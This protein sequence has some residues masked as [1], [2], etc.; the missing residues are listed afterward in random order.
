MGKEAKIGLAVILGLL[1]ILG[2]VITVR[3][4]SFARD[5]GPDLAD[6]TPGAAGAESP[7]SKEAAVVPAATSSQ[8]PSG[9]ASSS[10]A[11]QDRKPAPAAAPKPTVLSPED[12]EPTTRGAAQWRQFATTDDSTN[13][14]A[15]PYG[16][17][18]PSYMPGPPLPAMDEAT[19]RY[20][21]AYA[22][23]LPPDATAGYASAG[24]DAGS[25]H[26]PR[27]GSRHDASAA[28]GPPTPPYGDPRRA[29]EPSTGP[30][31]HEEGFAVA[32]RTV[33]DPRLGHA[34]DAG[35][36]SDGTYE[37]QPNDSFWTISRKLY[38]TGA[39]FQALAEHNRGKVA[40]Q[41]QLQVG[42]TIAAPDVAELEQKY[43][44]YCPKPE[45]RYVARHQP[46][47]MRVDHRGA[48][49]TYTV[50]EGDTLYRIARYELGDATRWYEV[51]KLNREVIGERYN[52]LRPGTQI[53]L[54]GNNDSQPTDTLTRRPGSLY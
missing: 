42:Q 13:S 39:Y 11:R 1:L 34:S 7:E 2:V 6:D 44:A 51:Y 23:P 4:A 16:G 47:S 30:G 5:A 18:S 20:G 22:A 38:G 15:G 9:S 3:V 53:I 17:S 24:T 43:P 21:S 54:P 46:A 41:D 29:V 8:K 28:E 12:P 26:N 50:V 36:R 45:H 19:E 14:A 40:N 10:P 49:A 31:R 27:R 25:E 37:V 33:S 32:T 48:D 35:R 52:H